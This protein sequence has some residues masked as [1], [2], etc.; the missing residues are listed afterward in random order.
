VLCSSDKEY[1]ELVEPFCDAFSEKG[2]CILAGDPGEF[3]ERYR[4]AGMDLFIHKEMNI[5]AMLLNIQN[6]L[7]EMEQDHE[8]T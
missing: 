1:E 3:E 6:D 4:A 7:F 5:P 8:T 2:I